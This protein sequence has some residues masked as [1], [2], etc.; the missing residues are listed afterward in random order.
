MVGLQVFVNIGMVA[1]LLPVVGLPLPILSY[2]GS[3][4]VTT[5]FGL[6]LVLNIALRRGRL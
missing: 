4:M 2:G 1:G 6:G 5:L 3:A